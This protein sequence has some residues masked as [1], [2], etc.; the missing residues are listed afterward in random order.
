[1]EGFEIRELK[2]FEDNRGW[3]GEILRDDEY[4]FKPAMSYL[5][6][7]KPGRV[8]GPHEHMDQTDYFCFIGKFRIYLWD[9]R[10]KSST[11]Q[12]HKILDTSGIPTVVLI[13]PGIVHAYKNIEKKDAYVINLPDKLYKGWGKNDQVDEVRYEDQPDSPYRIVD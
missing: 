7:T 12:Q 2:L 13:P 3:L 1:M 11:F 4:D 9:N 8:R 5:S 6:M 10:K